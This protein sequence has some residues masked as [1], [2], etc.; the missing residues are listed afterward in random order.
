MKR[1]NSTGLY[2][3]GG[4]YWMRFTH[5]G[6]YYRRSTE[7]SDRKIAAQII[8]TIKAQ[9]TLGQYVPAEETGPENEYTFAE[10]VTKHDEWAAPRHKAWKESGKCMSNH[11]SICLGEILVRDF[12]ARHVEQFQSA[13][14]ARGKSPAYINRQVTLL[15]SMFTK[16]VDW[17][18]CGEDVLRKVRKA[19]ALKGV[20]NRL[21]YL[22]QDECR[23]LIDKCE[24]HLKPIVSMALNTGMRKGEILSLK[25]DN[26]DLKHG[27]ILLDRTKNDERREIPINNTL[28]DVLQG[29]TRRLDIPYVFYDQSN[30]KPF[31]DI[32]KSFKTALKNAK[33][34]DFHFHDLRH[35]FSSQMIMAGVD[36]T[37]VSRLQGHK[38]L[39]MTLRYSHLSPAHNVE[40]VRKMDAFFAEKK[41]KLAQI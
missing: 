14:I 8:E 5:N 36:I 15:K 13:E 20:V 2:L 18:M 34:Y 26:V 11:L 21:R 9:I 28:R 19:K 17:D 25:W 30:G 35:T 22:S 31:G 40:A 4:T 38:S 3:R 23:T 39:K 16:A 6:I 41:A 27:F 1:N 10:L 33:I 32:K 37:T 24:S 7:T 29:L 12:T